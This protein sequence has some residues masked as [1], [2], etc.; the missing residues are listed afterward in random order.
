M[1]RKVEPT[2]RA[3]GGE[4]ADDWS[5]VGAGGMDAPDAPQ[6]RVVSALRFQRAEGNPAIPEDHRM[7]GAGDVQPAGLLYVGTVV[8][9]HEQLQGNLRIAARRH[10]GVAVAGE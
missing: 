8:V 7:Q 10:M 4:G 6:D 5:P 3:A 2:R 1:L 9:H